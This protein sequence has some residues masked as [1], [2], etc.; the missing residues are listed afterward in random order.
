MRT[1]SRI[2]VE[3]C[4]KRPLV[5]PMVLKPSNAGVP[6]SGVSKKTGR[7]IGMLRFRICYFWD[8]RV[9]LARRA[10]VIYWR[11]CF[12]FLDTLLSCSSSSYSESDGLSVSSSS[13]MFWTLTLHLA[14]LRSLR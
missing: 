7:P 8:T 6:S 4:W 9:S 2:Y 3:G 11:W 5:H 12:L 1:P 13:S 14:F 10:V